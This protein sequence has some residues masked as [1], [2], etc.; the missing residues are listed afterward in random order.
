M[1]NPD[2]VTTQD[3]LCHGD[4]DLPKYW[5]LSSANDYGTVW[6]HLRSVHKSNQIRGRAFTAE[7]FSDAPFTVYVHKQ[8]PGDL[9][10]VP[11]RWYGIPCEYAIANPVY[12][13]A[14]VNKSMRVLPGVSDGTA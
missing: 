5:F 7:E 10:V 9:L 8:E 6:D 14:S 1:D 11:P 12:F 4:P 3:L 13:S 2:S